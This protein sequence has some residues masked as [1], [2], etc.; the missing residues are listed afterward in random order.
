MKGKKMDRDKISNKL[1]KKLDR[2]EITSEQAFLRKL[3]KFDSKRFG[4]DY[5][6]EKINKI[7]KIHSLA[8]GGKILIIVGGCDCD[9]TEYDGY[10]YLVDANFTAVS[11]FE[12]EQANGAD[13]V[14]GFNYDKPSNE[15]NYSYSSRDLALEAY[16]NGH[17]H[18]IYRSQ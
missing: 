1:L 17:N 9:G 3:G 4:T 16:E 18:I 14:I 11:H 13:G 12:N 15:G 2:G 10:T 7:K 5:L 8:E 6:A